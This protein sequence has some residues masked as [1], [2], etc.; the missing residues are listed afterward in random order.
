MIYI[1]SLN[2]MLLMH[3]HHT[4]ELRVC[5]Y[6]SVAPCLFLAKSTITKAAEEAS[7]L[8]SGQCLK[9]VDAK[10]ITPPMTGGC[11]SSSST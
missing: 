6:E 2:V 1:Y 3:M 4:H 7:L 11:G 10:K 5:L 8:E 9:N